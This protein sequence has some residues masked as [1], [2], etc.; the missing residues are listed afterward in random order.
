[1]TRRR[2]RWT[3]RAQYLA[4]AVCTLFAAAAASAVLVLLTPGA[5]WGDVGQVLQ[6]WGDAAATVV[7]LVFLYGLLLTLTFAAF[8]AVRDVRGRRS[9]EMRRRLE[10]GALRAALARVSGNPSMDLP[11]RERIR[12]Q[13]L[14]DAQTVDD[15]DE[16]RRRR[17]R[18][19]GGRS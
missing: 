1:M 18:A 17:A 9:G 10:D 2:W 6:L 15:L 16:A 13:L 8:N 5:G 11:T 4:T 7:G 14:A 19:A 3:R 12:R